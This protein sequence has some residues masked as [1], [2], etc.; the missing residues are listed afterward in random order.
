MRGVLRVLLWATWGM[1]L[2]AQVRLP[3]GGGTVGVPQANGMAPEWDVRAILQ[4][5]SAHATRLGPL[6][7]RIDAKAWVAKGAPDTYTAQLQSAKDQARAIAGGAKD[8]ARQPEKLSAA[9]ELY[10]RI[11]GL[12]NM[13]ASLAEGIRKYQNPA[14]A[15][16]LTSVAA[17]NG[18]NRDRF[19][20]YIVDMVVEREQQF[21]VMDHEAQRCRGILARQ[22]VEVPANS[23]RTK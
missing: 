19:Q 16:L 1:V 11:Q 22:P 13:M 18:A 7:D 4:E 9:L 2:A 21:T 14:L 20:R 10:F 5:M 12:D 15:E 23:G 6:L 17:E 3:A 8:L